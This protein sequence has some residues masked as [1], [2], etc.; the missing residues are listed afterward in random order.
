[1]NHER[2]PVVIDKLQSILEAVRFQFSGADVHTVGNIRHTAA[3]LIDQLL[4]DPDCLEDELVDQIVSNTERAL[5]EFYK[6]KYH[7]H[8]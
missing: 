7:L 3:L 6:K 2:V 4:D 1:M 8:S 5:V